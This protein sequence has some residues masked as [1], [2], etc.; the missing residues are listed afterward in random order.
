MKPEAKANAKPR[1]GAPRTS[2]PDAPKEL[3]GTGQLPTAVS[4]R[5]TAASGS[6]MGYHRSST[7]A[8]KAASGTYDSTAGKYSQTQFAEAMRSP[9]AR[10]APL[11]KLSPHTGFHSG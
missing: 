10:A 8:E 1:V 11:A 6:T 9:P 5:Y 2:K 3:E 4:T 7:Y